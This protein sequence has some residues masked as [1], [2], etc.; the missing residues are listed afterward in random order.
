VKPISQRPNLRLVQREPLASEVCC[1]SQRYRKRCILGPGAQ[2]AL[3]TAPVNAW[4]SFITG[5]NPGGHAIFDF[6]HRDPATF[7]P[8]LSTSRSYPS[9]SAINVGKWSLPLGSGRVDLLRKGPALWEP[10]EEHD[11]PATIYQVPANFPVIGKGKTKALSG[12][13]TPDL[14]GG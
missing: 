13:G 12:M 3:M 14:L 4:A 11:I 8:Y 2:T 5:S 9:E 7:L 10:F 6:I 1:F